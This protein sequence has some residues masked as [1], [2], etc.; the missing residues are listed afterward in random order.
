MN[1]FYTP[2]LGRVRRRSRVHEFAGQPIQEFRMRG[3][4]HP[5][6]EILGRGNQAQAKIGLPHSIDHD[7]SGGRTAPVCDPFRESQSI[8]RSTFRE[9]MQDRRHRGIH[10]FSRP[11]SISSFEEVRLPWMAALLQ[12]KRGRW[13]RPVGPEI[14]DLMVEVREARV[15]Q[16]EQVEDLQL[17]W[18]PPQQ[19]KI[20]DLFRLSDAGFTNL[21]HQID[22]L[23][24]NWPYPPTTLVLQQRS[25]PRQTHLFKRGDRLRPGEEV[26]A[27]VPAVLHRFPEGAPRN[28]L[29]LAKWIADRRSPTTSRVMVNR[30]WQAYFRLGLVTTPEDFGTRVE[31]PSHPELLDWLACEFMDPAA[32]SDS[33]QSWSIKHIHRLIVNSA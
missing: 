5:R 29:G 24:T 17:L 1:V 26:D 18:S 23:W 28:R 4:F 7:A 10:F 30:M 6:P 25:H 9:A 14:V 27:A 20:F 22:N 33:A 32:T 21:N 3:R 11:Q 19:L 16:A 31:T 12:N 15:R 2:G 13:I 8:S